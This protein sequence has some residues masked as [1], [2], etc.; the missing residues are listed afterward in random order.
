VDNLILVRTGKIYDYD[1][2]MGFGDS[3]V[4]ANVSEKHTVYIFRA[5]VAILGRVYIHI[6]PST[7]QHRQFSPEDRDSMFLRNVGIYQRV[8]TAPKPRSSSSSPP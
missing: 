8:Y 3:S 7:S 5:E 1:V 4:D 2:L 6:H